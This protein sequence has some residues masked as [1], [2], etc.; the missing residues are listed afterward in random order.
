MQERLRL[1]IAA[2]LTCLLL[3]AVSVAGLL[4]HA[5]SSAPTAS[6]PAPLTTQA[7]HTAPAPSWNEEH[8]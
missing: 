7:T 6:A 2:T 3:A 8:D 1:I 5:G 4:S